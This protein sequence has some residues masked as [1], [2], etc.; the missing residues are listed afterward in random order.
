[1]PYRNL[2]EHGREEPRPWKLYPGY[3]GLLCTNQ[4]LYLTNSLSIWNLN[5]ESANPRM[6]V[7][8]PASW[9]LRWAS[10]SRYLRRLKRLDIREMFQTPSGSLLGVGQKIIV[11][12]R[13]E[14]LIPRTVLHVKEGGR[15]KGFTATPA[16]HLF[17]GEYWGNPHRKPLRIWGSDDDGRSW[18]TVYSTPVGRAKHIHNLVWDDHRQG[19]WVLTG[20]ADHESALLFTDDGFQTVT[21][22]AGGSQMFRA[23]QLFCRSEGIYYATDTERAKNWFLFLEAGFEKLHRL[24]PLPGS[25]IYAA[26]MAGRHFLSTSVEPSQVN[27]HRSAALWSSKDLQ[28]WHQVIEF[29]KDCWPG[30]YFGFGSIMLPRVQGETSVVLFSTVALKPY[31]L[32]TFWVPLEELDRLQAEGRRQ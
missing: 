3:L 21:E 29:K 19:I 10:Q 16:G 2:T 8:L 22:V 14:E 7:S 18:E 26:T 25:C 13:Q 28:S 17:V 1:M 9:P 23:C 15:P 6:L 32:T 30:E 24:Q 20:D 27:R 4:N 31:D 5:G 11:R 12:F